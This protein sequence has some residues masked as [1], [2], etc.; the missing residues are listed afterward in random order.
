MDGWVGSNPL[1]ALLSVNNTVVD[2]WSV[3]VSCN[4]RPSFHSAKISVTD[5]QVY[6]AISQIGWEK[7]RHIYILNSL[8]KDIPRDRGLNPNPLGGYIIIALKWMF[9]H[10]S[11]CVAAFLDSVSKGY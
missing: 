4:G 3:R 1:R 9:N 8:P 7:L 5:N 6:P 10:I 11:K 2:N